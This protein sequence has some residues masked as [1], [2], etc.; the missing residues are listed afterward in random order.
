L[1]TKTQNSKVVEKSIQCVSK[2]FIVNGQKVYWE[3]KFLTESENGNILN[4]PFSYTGKLIRTSDK[5]TILQ[6]TEIKFSG[7]SA[8]IQYDEILRGDADFGDINLDG[9]L[10]YSHY[11]EVNSGSGGSFYITYIYNKNLKIFEESEE[12]SGGGLAVDSLKRTVSSYWK[13]GVG[14]NQ[15]DEKYLDKFGKIKYI[16]RTTRE[17][18][19]DENNRDYLVTTVQKIQGKKSTQIKKDT[20]EFEG[21]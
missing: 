16:M 17:V 9:Y 8:F 3:Y 7:L 6:K 15:E 2:P 4:N 14:W 13:S 18:I 20:V 11:S 21:Y 19:H 10:D 1:T 5:K 12:F